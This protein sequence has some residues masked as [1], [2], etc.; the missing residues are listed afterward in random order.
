MKSGFYILGA[1]GPPQL[2][3]WQRL[4]DYK[5]P[6]VWG[7]NNKKKTQLE[8]DFKLEVEAE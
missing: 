8:L 5:F 6:T 4:T 2:R 7:S 1:M 3:H